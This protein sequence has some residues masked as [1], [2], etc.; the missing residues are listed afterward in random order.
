MLW[1]KRVLEYRQ[2]EQF[3]IAVFPISSSAAFMVIDRLMRH[4]H[5][6]ACGGAENCRHHFPRPAVRA[7]FC[8]DGQFCV[9][10]DRFDEMLATHSPFLTQLLG[11]HIHILPIATGWML[12][13]SYVVKY[14]VNAEARSGSLPLSHNSTDGDVEHRLSMIGMSSS[15]AM[16]RICGMRMLRL[17]CSFVEI[18][19]YVKWRGTACTTRRGANSR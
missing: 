1:L 19:P 15:T 9:P 6:A 7:I 16:L 13:M 4:R 17:S 3:V 14:Y 5:C 2:I 18:T 11:Q 12:R 10:G 8:E